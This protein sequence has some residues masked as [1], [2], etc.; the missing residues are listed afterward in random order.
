MR[1]GRSSSPSSACAAGGPPARVRIFGS[2]LPSAGTCSTI[3][4][5]AGKLR[6][7]AP[8]TA[9]SASTPP[10]EA[11]TTTTRFTGGS[12]PVRRIRTRDVSRNAGGQDLPFMRNRLQ[13]LDDRARR[14]REAQDEL[15][16]THALI[17]SLSETLA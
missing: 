10:A 4:T 6:G 7:S 2:L 8:A 1:S 15:E 3:A 13:E 12:Y 5:G 16:R 9:A 14:A 11:P 17:H